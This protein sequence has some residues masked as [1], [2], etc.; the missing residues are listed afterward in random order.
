MVFLI[1][2]LWQIAIIQADRLK[3]FRGQSC[4]ITHNFGHLSWLM[5]TAQV[6]RLKAF[7]FQPSACA[8]KGFIYA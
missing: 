6:A 1:R 5:V 2:I 7:S 4:V 8:I 3:A